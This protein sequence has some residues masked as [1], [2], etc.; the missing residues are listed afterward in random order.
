MVSTESDISALYV[1][2]Q[3]LSALEEALKKHKTG[4]CLHLLFS[5]VSAIL[6]Y[7]LVITVHKPIEGIH[8]LK[9]EY[10]FITFIFV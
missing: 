2:T 8:R 1:L 9:P 3:S 6:K 4:F 10:G 7:V 5:N